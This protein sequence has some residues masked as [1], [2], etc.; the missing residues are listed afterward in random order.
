MFQVIFVKL[1]PGY[2]KVFGPDQFVIMLNHGPVSDPYIK[3]PLVRVKIVQTVFIAEICNFVDHQIVE[4]IS[5][6]YGPGLLMPMSTN[7]NLHTGH[8]KVPG[9]ALIFNLEWREKLSGF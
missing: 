6:A 7:I 5:H 2:L 8:I 4:K 1:D 3:Y 9:E